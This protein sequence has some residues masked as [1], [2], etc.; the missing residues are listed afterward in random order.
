MDYVFVL[1]NDGMIDGVSGKA[2][3]QKTED[4]SI[5]LLW[6]MAKRNAAVKYCAGHPE[7]KNN[8][9]VLATL[10]NG[11]QNCDE[12]DQRTPDDVASFMVNLS[13]GPLL[14]FQST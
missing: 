3:L 11:C 4:P 12:F 5:W 6:S 1:L 8:P 10:L 14:R 2:W 9:N 13:N 7:H